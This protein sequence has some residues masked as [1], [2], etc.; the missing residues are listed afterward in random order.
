MILKVLVFSVSTEDL[1]E[2]QIP[3]LLELEPTQAY[4][5]KNCRAGTQQ[6]VSLQIPQVSLTHS[7]VWKP[8]AQ[9]CQI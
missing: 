2:M 4:R 9:G 8:L 6:S 3:D 7:G 5:I 1:L